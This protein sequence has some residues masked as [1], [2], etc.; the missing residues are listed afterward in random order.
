MRPVPNLISAKTHGAEYLLHKYW[1]RKPHNVIGH[2]LDCL[3]PDG[4]LVVDPFCGSGVVLREA[5][6][7]G[8]SALGFD[9]NPVAALISSVTISPPTVEAFEA[10]IRPRVESL[11]RRAFE[12]Y[13]YR[14]GD[15][16]VRYLVHQLI[17]ECLSC[18]SR[19]LA[20]A[21]KR[22]GRTYQCPTCGTRIRFG[23][24]SALGTGILEAVLERDGRV[25]HDADVLQQQEAWCSTLVLADASILEKYKREF[26][27]NTRTLTFEGM[28]SDM[29]F[30][31]RNFS[32]LCETAEAF[33]GIGEERV[34][35]AA[36]AML[37]ASVAQASRLIPYRQ[38]S[39]TGG[40][41]WSVP[42]FWV[43]PVHLESNPAFHLRARFKKFLRG[44]QV[45]NHEP[46]KGDVAVSRIDA[47]RGLSDLVSS[48]RKA[49]LVFLDPPYGDSVPYLEFSC[50]WNSFLEGDVE[51]DEDISV[52]NRIDASVGWRR[53]EEALE[54]VVQLAQ[55]SLSCDGRVLITFNNH[56]SRAWT[57]LLGALQSATLACEFVS[58]QTPAVVS[59][60]AQFSPKGS[61]TSDIYG[62][63]ARSPEPPSEDLNPVREALKRCASSRDG[64]LTRTVAL[65]ALMVAWV[66]NNISAALIERR[67]DLIAELFESSTDCLIWKGAIDETVPRLK[68]VTEAVVDRLLSSGG[69]E[70]S[71]LY[72][73]VATILRSCGVPDPWE[74]QA[75][76]DGRVSY[77]GGRLVTTPPH[78]LSLV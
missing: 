74:I 31:P 58:Y 38:R 66:S 10:E 18:G 15:E 42:G 45:L 11:E 20:T 24:Q 72:E 52:S 73:A 27:E 30:T 63:F 22:V 56:D 75:S 5:A 64:V 33:G 34:R 36:F 7:R 54:K 68:Q 57:A 21:T 62:L 55:Q 23:L 61:Y 48:G 65:R 40:P 26:P 9:V 12:Q 29:L 70:W 41:A 2:L 49:D 51:F 4:G 44:L 78:Q 60:K 14:I 69:C 32:F 71:E 37:T 50:L 46:V 53:Y 43:P 67:D 16:P 39:S 6:K 3:V 47:R 76:L 1:A 17:A 19:V 28:R 59:S 8:F 35:N 13:E 25:V 77:R